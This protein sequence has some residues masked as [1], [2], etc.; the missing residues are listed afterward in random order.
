VWDVEVREERD[1]GRSLK[2]KGNGWERS[3]RGGG[4]E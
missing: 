2:Q 3:G 1:C 4:G